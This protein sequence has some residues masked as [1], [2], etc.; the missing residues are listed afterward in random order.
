MLY[1]EY[2]QIVKSAYVLQMPYLTVYNRKKIIMLTSMTCE[3]KSYHVIC[4]LVL[5]SKL[6]WIR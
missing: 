5:N 2:N 6:I 3:D 1:D 4:F